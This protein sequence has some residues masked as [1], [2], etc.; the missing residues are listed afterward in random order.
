MFPRGAGIIAVTYQVAVLLMDLPLY[1]IL[2]WWRPLFVPT[3]VIYWVMA[4]PHRHG[5][6]EVFVI[7]L[8]LSEH[9][10]TAATK[11]SQLQK[12]HRPDKTSCFCGRTQTSVNRSNGPGS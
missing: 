1:E 12:L 4:L 6:W 5:I 8:F 2:G 11:A 9:E 10:Q 3:V 7:G